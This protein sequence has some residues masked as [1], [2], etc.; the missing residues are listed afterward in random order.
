MILRA[1][2]AGRQLCTE[3]DAARAAGS[4]E[5]FARLPAEERATLARIFRALLEGEQR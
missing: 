1:T 5:L 3:V 4:R 2:T